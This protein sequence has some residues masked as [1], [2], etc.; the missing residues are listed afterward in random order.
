MM[1][2]VNPSP[3]TVFRIIALAIFLVSLDATI[4]VAAFP[5]LRNEFRISLPTDLSWVMNAYTIATASLLVPSGRLA[6]LMGRKKIFISGLLLFT[7]GSLLC[8]VSVNAGMLIAARVVQALGAA[9]LTPASLALVLHA[10]PKEKRAVAVSLWSV[11][12]ALAAA[13]GPALGSIVIEYAS[14]RWAFLINLPLGLVAWWLAHK[15]L[16]E[17]KSPE[18]GAKLDVVGVILITLGGFL[19]T[20]GI[21]QSETWGWNN[22][23]T[24][25]SIVAGIASLLYFVMWAKD[26]TSAA[27][28][29]ALFD[30]KTYRYVTLATLVFGIAFSMMFLSSFLYLMGIWKYQQS[31]T[32]IAV[33]AGP[34]MVIPIAV[35]SGKFAAKYG[36][37]SQLVLGGMLYATAQLWQWWHVS[38]VADYWGVWFPSQVI[39]GASIGLLLPGLSGAAVARLPPQLFGVGGAVNNAVRQLGGVLGTAITVVMVG[40]EN[41]PIESFA[42]VFL[43]LTAVGVTTA[44]LSLPV[45]TK[46][47]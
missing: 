32:G 15:T 6:D 41:A 16:V 39:G 35:L 31:V 47:K 8:G 1:A 2:Q 36:H 45:N 5:A 13:I 37:R 4:V 11:F 40:K 19:I 46:P 7:L 10:F 26:K 28:D 22:V 43:I 18:I 42:N 38:P 20:L 23:K 27:I 12:G 14:W 17:S 25:A 3:W 44:I 34:L 30:D 24:A 33:S 21:V 9:M 29:L